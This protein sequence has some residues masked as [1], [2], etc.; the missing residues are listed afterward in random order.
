MD[1]GGLTF[2][3]LWRFVKLGDENAVVELIHR[4]RPLIRNESYVDGRHDQDLEQ[5]ITEVFVQAL[6][7]SG[8]R[9]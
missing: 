6:I 5:Q 3:N 2:T 1:Y 7:K 4:F 8:P 9:E